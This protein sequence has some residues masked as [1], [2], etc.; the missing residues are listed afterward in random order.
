MGPHPSMRPDASTSALAKNAVRP[1]NGHRPTARNPDGTAVTNQRKTAKDA[2]GSPR[3]RKKPRVADSDSSDDE[4]LQQSA[5]RL[6]GELMS[7]FQSPAVKHK[8]SSI[9][10]IQRRASEPGSSKA[11]ANL[12]ASHG[13]LSRG[14][15]HQQ[16]P[17]ARSSHSTSSQQ[18]SL[19]KVSQAA[20]SA[21]A[22]SSLPRDAAA[23]QSSCPPFSV[24][25]EDGDRTVRP[26]LDLDLK[27]DFPS[28]D[29][30]RAN[31]AETAKNRLGARITSLDDADAFLGFALARGRVGTWDT[32]HVATQTDYAKGICV[33]RLELSHNVSSPSQ[34][35][36]VTAT[37]SRKAVGVVDKTPKL[38]ELCAKMELV[39]ALVEPSTTPSDFLA[40]IDPALEQRTDDQKKD[41]EGCDLFERYRCDHPLRLIK[42]I[43]ARFSRTGT[44]AYADD[45][46]SLVDAIANGLARLDGS[47]EEVGFGPWVGV[48]AASLR[49]CLGVRLA[50]RPVA[51]LPA[52]L[53]SSKC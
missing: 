53:K 16:A 47:A 24:R 13:S 52:N 31:A 6:S 26:P 42:A 21:T 48:F 1:A 37:V 45:C 46:A 3:K 27:F 43:E 19:V 39:R 32:M 8:S 30:R 2:D 11:P 40:Q 9:P 49:K 15:S 33:V 5:R 51:P 34:L 20:R 50:L 4:P 7:P 18:S 44:L 41:S 22:S 35:V 38:A 28:P 36:Q 29:A 14:T 23:G 17:P 10:V 25:T 12:A